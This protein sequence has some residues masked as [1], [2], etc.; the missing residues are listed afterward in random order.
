[1]YICIKIGV[2]SA[3]TVQHGAQQN[4]I[5]NRM[6]YGIQNRTCRIECR[7]EYRIECRIGGYMGQSRMQNRNRIEEYIWVRVE[8]RIECRIKELE[9]NGIWGRIDDR[10]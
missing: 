7:I 8:L 6:V 10:I 9:Q 3:F 1:M 5:Q 2:N 4:R